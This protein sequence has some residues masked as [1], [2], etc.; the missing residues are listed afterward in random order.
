MSRNILF[1]LGISIAINL[2][3]MGFVASRLFDHPFHGPRGEHGGG[4]EAGFDK[5]ISGL[6]KEYQDKVRTIFNQHHKMV[7]TQM[8]EMHVLFAQM[9]P[10][11]TAS[12]FDA[13]KFE[14]LGRKIDDHDK[15]IKGSMGQMM[16]KI[17]TVLPDDER[18]KF[19]SQIFT[20]RPFPGP[21]P[22]GKKDH[23]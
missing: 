11:L 20:D 22:M 6:D 2:F 4:P 16:S 13:A 23:P 1:I 17:A 19:F 15:Q 12:H 21:P 8:N 14:A 18:I 7:E 5:A 3:L 9:E 10:T